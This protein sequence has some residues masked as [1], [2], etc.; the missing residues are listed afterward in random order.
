[1]GRAR[2]PFPGWV[3]LALVA[4]SVPGTSGCLDPG[5]AVLSREDT[6]APTVVSTKPAANE[7]AFAKDAE[8]EITF[9]EAMDPRSLAPGIALRTGQDL[10]VVT[11]SIPAPTGNE[12]DPNPADIPYTVRARPISGARWAV[13]QY[14]LLLRTLLS[15][16][17]GNALAQEV[18]VA[19]TTGP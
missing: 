3:A 18:S 15:D 5:R 8:L 10:L 11:V 2:R 7:A 14:Q 19:F 4:G 12:D 17:E 6:V 13:T 16:T 1:M 9:S